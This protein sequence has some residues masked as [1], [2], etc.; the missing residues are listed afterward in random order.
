MRENAIKQEP[1]VI[2]GDVQMGCNAEW[3]DRENALKCS[4]IAYFAIR[5]LHDDTGRMW[6][7]DTII[8]VVGGPF[9]TKDAAMEFAK[10][11]LF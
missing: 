2:T 5:K 6:S 11:V 10:S 1:G 9:P 7:K 4:S 3:Y 8:Q